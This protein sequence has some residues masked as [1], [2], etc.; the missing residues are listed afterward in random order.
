M[1]LII[2]FSD[3]LNLPKSTFSCDEIVFF[4]TQKKQQK[5]TIAVKLGEK[6]HDNFSGP[7]QHG[8]DVPHKVI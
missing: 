3:V 4:E 7:P 2:Y 6:K 1:A 5:C 8:A